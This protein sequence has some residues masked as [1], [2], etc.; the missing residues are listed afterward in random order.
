MVC[1]SFLRFFWARFNGTWQTFLTPALG[2]TSYGI[3]V[4]KNLT[5]DGSVFLAGYGDEPSSHW[6]EIVPR[7]Q[8]AAG[9]MISVGCTDAASFPGRL[10]KVPQAP[11]TFKYITMNYS[12]FAGFP[13]PLTNGGL[14]EHHV[15]GRDIWSPSRKELRAMT[16][17]PQ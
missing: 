9:A 8:H 1:L 3:Y 10:I 14:N 15:A 5:A 16:P 17:R 7:R 4:G 13:A 2:Q 11:V 6:L 12:S